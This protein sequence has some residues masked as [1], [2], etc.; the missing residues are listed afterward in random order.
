MRKLKERRSKLEGKIFNSTKSRKTTI[1]NQPNKGSR[2]NRNSID[3]NN[4][5]KPNSRLPY[6]IYPNPLKPSRPPRTNSP[7]PNPAT[8]TKSHKSSVSSPNRDS[9]LSTTE[10]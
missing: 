5:Y 2:C 10:R 9:N 7:A 1:N 3:K 8:M 6:Q 4:S